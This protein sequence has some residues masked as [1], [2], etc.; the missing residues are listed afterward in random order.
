MD[1]Y[2]LYSTS[3]PK[4]EVLKKKM[5]EKMIQYQENTS[6]E[7]MCALG[8]THV[9]ILSINGVYLDFLDAVKWVNK[10]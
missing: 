2:I 3:C 5:D 8:L 6:V 9:P 7:E 10:Q 1:E 4:C